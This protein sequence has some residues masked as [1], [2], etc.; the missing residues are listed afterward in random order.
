MIRF[1]SLLYISDPE[2]PDDGMYIDAIVVYRSNAI[3][4]KSVMN[5]LSHAKKDEYTYAVRSV[6]LRWKKLLMIDLWL[7]RLRFEWIKSV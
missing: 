2:V 5:D 4:Y 1:R 6:P 3:E 7:I